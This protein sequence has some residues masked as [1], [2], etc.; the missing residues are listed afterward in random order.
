MKIQ[1][2]MISDTNKLNLTRQRSDSYCFCIPRAFSPAD[3]GTFRILL[4]PISGAVGVCSGPR[5]PKTRKN[6]FWKDGKNCN[7]V[8]VCEIDLF[9]MLFFGKRIFVVKS[10]NRSRVKETVCLLADFLLQMRITKR[11]SW[12]P[13]M[14]R[15]EQTSS[16]KNNRRK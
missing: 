10:E 16:S 9:C 13:W 12:L 2:T 1:I 11:M 15:G 3:T 4:I 6:N 5:T 8:A 14:A 7:F